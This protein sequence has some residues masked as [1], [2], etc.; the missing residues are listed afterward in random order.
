MIHCTLLHFTSLHFRTSA[1]TPT[2]AGMVSLVNFARLRA[3]LEPIGWLNPSL[4]KYSEY[5]ANDI[6]SGSNFCVA[7]RREDVPPV[8]CDQGYFATKGWDPVTGIGSVD[9]AR[10]L[11]FFS[12]D[13]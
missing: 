8:C 5:Y 4:Y 11:A 3:G 13:H 2:F 7:T 1:S 10:F 9:F 6:T 12:R